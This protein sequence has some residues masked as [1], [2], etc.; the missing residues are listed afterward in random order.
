MPQRRRQVLSYLAGALGCATLIAAA[1]FLINSLVDPLWYLRGN[2][3]TGINYPFNE[4]LSKI[5][6]FLPRLRDY[7]CLII[8]SSR[9][10]L[11][12]VESL[13]GYRCVNFAFSDGQIG[14]FL[15]YARY[16]RARGMAPKLL[17]VDLRREDFIGP[18]P[19][20]D[21]PD[22]IRTGAAPPSIFASYLS[23]DALGFSIRTLQGDAPHHR[24]YDPNF[25][26]RL[27]VRSAKHRYNPASPVEPMP[28]PFDVHPERAELYIELR[29]IFPRARAI[30]YVPPE[31]ASRIAAF[32]L[33]GGLDAY[34]GAIGRIATAYDEVL[35]FA[36]PSSL[37]ES[38][39]GTYDGSHYSETVGAEIATA[40]LNDKPE[41]GID[42][43]RNDL[44]TITMLYHL[45]LREFL[46]TTKH[47]KAPSG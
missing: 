8:G 25:D 47:A 24:Y 33:T 30:G 39:Q 38:P 31:S 11:L 44:S 40:L 3:L 43:R 26:A 12:P 41:P 9:A 1:C 18:L 2:L 6:Q 37:T 4:R 27:E 42:W 46:D 21:V 28:P 14:E 36:I 17:I 35:D 5:N 19:P 45:R 7:D 16:L 23:L 20:P 32:S 29:Q 13:T 10:T 34:L 22:F 15:L